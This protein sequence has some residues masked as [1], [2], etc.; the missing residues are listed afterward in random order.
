MNASQLRFFENSI[1]GSTSALLD[2]LQGA[3]AEHTKGGD[4][5]YLLGQAEGVAKLIAKTIS[6]L[7][8]RI[9]NE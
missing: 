1:R 5:D 2:A 8:Q 9:S 3:K 7:R 4:A 6:E